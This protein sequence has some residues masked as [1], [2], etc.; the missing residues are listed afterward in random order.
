MCLSHAAFDGFGVKGLLHCNEKTHS[1]SMLRMYSAL[2]RIG[3][4]VTTQG[5]TNPHPRP[6]YY[7]FGHSG[8]KSSISSRKMLPILASS[9]RGL[10]TSEAML[11]YHFGH[12]ESRTALTLLTSK[13]G[14]LLLRRMKGI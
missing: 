12:L 14:P 5:G 8:L 6:K 13:V 9:G 11:C 2:L 7:H 3:T 1:E 10:A 4:G